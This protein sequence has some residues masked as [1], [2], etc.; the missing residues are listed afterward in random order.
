MV[1]DQ[2]SETLGSLRTTDNVQSPGTEQYT[3]VSILENV[4]L[5]V[6]SSYSLS[7]HHSC[8][9]SSLL[10]KYVTLA[11]VLLTKYKEYKL[12]LLHIS[13]ASLGSKA[14]GQKT[15]ILFLGSERKLTNEKG[16]ERSYGCWN[17]SQVCFNHSIPLSVTVS[18]SVTISE[19][20][21]IPKTQKTLKCLMFLNIISCYKIMQ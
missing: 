17:E 12:S 10:Y 4:L 1:T 9:A 11:S 3:T 18:T 16:N 19:K 7:L 6:L 14:L 20:G 8:A 13:A 21:N 2:V 15:E 5:S